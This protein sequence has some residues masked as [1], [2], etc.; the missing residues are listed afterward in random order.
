VF[1]RKAKR[2][3][4]KRKSNAAVRSWTR[5]G[6]HVT[7]RA[8][9]MPGLGSAERTYRVAIVLANGRVELTGLTGEHTVTEFESVKRSDG[10]RPPAK[11]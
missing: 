10:T 11:A 3:R 8:E 6:A 9:V 1:K 5:V 4:A 2:A 7:F